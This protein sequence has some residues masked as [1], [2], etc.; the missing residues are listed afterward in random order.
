MDN[1]KF[2]RHPKMTGGFSN[3]SFKASLNFRILFKNCIQQRTSVQ[4]ILPRHCGSMAA[5][6]SQVYRFRSWRLW[7][8]GYHNVRFWMLDYTSAE[9]HSESHAFAKATNFFNAKNGNLLECYLEQYKV[10]MGH[11]NAREA[12]STVPVRLGWLHAS[13]NKLHDTSRQYSNAAEYRR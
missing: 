12:A 1:H 3:T 7:G 6:A 4:P 10:C 11:S 2:L 13:K 5:L 8:A 9:W